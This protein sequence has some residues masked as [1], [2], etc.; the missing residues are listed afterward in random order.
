[1]VSNLTKNVHKHT[2]VVDYVYVE[3]V[4]SIMFLHCLYVDKLLYWFITMCK[5]V[6]KC[7]DF[8]ELNTKMCGNVRNFRKCA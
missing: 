8:C 6:Q 7:A 4:F 3:N 5:N 1:M 2:L